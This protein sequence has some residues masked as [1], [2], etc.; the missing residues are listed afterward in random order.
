M[1][2]DLYK[3]LGVERSASQKDIQSAWRRLAR[4][5]HPDITGGDA[6][7]EQRFKEVNAAHDVL[8]DDQ[9]R[10]AY[11]KWGDRWEHAEQLEE[12]E[13]N[14]AFGFQ[15]PGGQPGGGFNP[16]SRRAGGGAY[17]FT[18]DD[19]GDLGDLGDLFGGLFN[20]G[21]REAAAPQGR[22]IEHPLT[23]SLTE[24]FHGAT[25]TIQSP[26]S[27]SPS[28]GEGPR[29]SRLEITIPPGVDTGSRVKISG[30]GG[31]PPGGPTGDLYLLVTV[32][33]DPRFE[34]KGDNL[35]TDI[36]L[37]VATA[38]LGGEVAVPTITG[39]VALRIPQGTQ[40]GRA[41]RLAGQG[42]PRRR[43]GKTSRA[44]KSGPRG[45]LFARARLQLPEPLTTEHLALFRQL[46]ALEHPD[47]SDD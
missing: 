13:R 31:G 26:Q 21:G 3:V 2:T 28:G 9:K 45:D 46:R 12:M 30:K 22:D 24:A 4:R 47:G 17:T 10:A 40:N 25:R 19:L 34:R 32:A 23:I 5:Y 41:F 43:G 29:F 7:A 38:A 37:P 14:G 27:P 36:D 44:G 39:Q 42:M 35:Y 20:F 1:A 15:Q 8:G 33:D 11:D 18:P 6:E 16:F